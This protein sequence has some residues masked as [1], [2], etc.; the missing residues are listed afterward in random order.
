MWDYDYDKKNVEKIAKTAKMFKVYNQD[1]G[2]KEP[3]E[4]TWH[5]KL[6]YY[7]IV[8]RI[9][10]RNHIMTYT[11][12]GKSFVVALGLLIRAVTH[13]EKWAIVAPS[14]NK[15]MIIMRII[16]EHC[17]DNDDIRRQLDME[18]G[19]KD[20]LR[21]EVS[22]KRITFKNG[23]E[24]FVLSADARNKDAAGEALM[25]FGS[26]NL[27]LDESSLIDDD[28][29]AKAKRMLGDQKNNFLLEIGNPFRRNHFHKAF[30]DSRYNHI[31]VDWEMGVKEGRTSTEHIEEMRNEAD[32][33]ILYNCNFPD[34]E[35]VRD[36]WS[37]LFPEHT[38]DT[39]Q[40]KEN[41]NS[42]GEKRLG[43]DLAAGGD[44][45]VWVL[46]TN[47]YARVIE[48]TQTKDTM[49][50]IGLTRRLMDEY[51]VEEGN[52]F[53]DA[54]GLGKGIQ[55]RFHEEGVNIEGINFASKALNDERFI[56][57]RA[58][59]YNRAAKWLKKGGTLQEHPDWSDL[60]HMRYKTRSNGKIQIVSK[61]QLS[62]WNI[63][64]PDVADAFILTF[65]RPDT[66]S[67]FKKNKKI[68]LTRSKQ[69]KYN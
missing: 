53:I 22:K 19:A 18:E 10:D 5:Q 32:F 65:A 2:K 6:V 42:F 46:R 40:I 52:C 9:P 35:Q 34:E 29:Y 67:R 20:R 54:T 48:K 23:G 15:A 25:G 31:R 37:L 38:I 1:T 50:A 62:K 11:R 55:D 28:I 51:G 57:I 30:K 68:Q 49:A 61:Q 24:I 58:E 16:I 64:S 3:V 21:R 12:F 47:D 41:P 39:A 36:G 45:T 27:V 63:H 66:I 4:L 8:K 26:P 7:T 13:Q 69:P 59:A 56:N 17:Y 43:V 60:V 44:Y 14:T 33:D